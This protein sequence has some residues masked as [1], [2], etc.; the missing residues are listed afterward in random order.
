PTRRSADLDRRTLRHTFT[1]GKTMFF[2]LRD[3]RTARWRFALITGVV[4][5]L[6][7][8][9]AGLLGLTAGLSN[10]SVSALKSLGSTG[11]RFV[12]PADVSGPV[13]LDRAA[14]PD[15]VRAEVAGAGG[16]AGP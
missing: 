14:L 9:V 1:R 7:V 4:L 5:M 16:A 3:L 10:Q 6:S 13:G 12:L 11:S 15:V 8:L 2:A